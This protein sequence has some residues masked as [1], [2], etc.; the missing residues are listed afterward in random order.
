VDVFDLSGLILSLHTFC[1]FQDLD[2]DGDDIMF[3]T[4][5]LAQALSSLYQQAT[6]A[7]Y[8]NGDVQ[9]SENLSGLLLG[10]QFLMYRNSLPS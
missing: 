9:Y 8:I 10:A 5:I 3:K 7:K 6:M 4:L 2:G 1:Q